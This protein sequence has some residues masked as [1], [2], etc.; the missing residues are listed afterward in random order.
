MT[1]TGSTNHLLAQAAA[2]YIARSSGVVRHDIALTLGSGWGKAADL[3]GETVADLLKMG[4]AWFANRHKNDTKPE[5]VEALW[6]DGA[7]A[8]TLGRAFQYGMG[9]DS[10]TNGIRRMVEATDADQLAQYAADRT[11]EVAEAMAR[12]AK[13]AEAIK[14]PKTLSDY[15]TWMRATMEGGKTFKEA[16]MMLTPEQRAAIDEARKDI[17]DTAVAAGQFKTLA[18][19]LQ[20]A[21]LIDT[22][23]SL[24]DGQIG[25]LEAPKKSEPVEPAHRLDRGGLGTRLPRGLRCRT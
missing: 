7:S 23:K 16:R 25:W 6:R 8:Y 24:K 14:D 17:V 22:L 4:G 12:V 18:T 11:A 5:V 2:E 13:V 21:G 1:N 19:A 9:K 10:Y 3:I 20:A 15:N